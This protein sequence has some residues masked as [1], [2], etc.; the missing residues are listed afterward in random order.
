MRVSCLFTFSWRAYLDGGRA[1][2]LAVEALIFRSD[3]CLRSSHTV[4]G[5]NVQLYDVDLRGDP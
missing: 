1:E 5:R 4:V 3:F 2:G